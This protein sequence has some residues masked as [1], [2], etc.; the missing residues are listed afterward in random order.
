MDSLP[1]SGPG[2][3]SAQLIAATGPEE[4]W[5]ATSAGWLFHYS[6][7]TILPESTDSS[8]GRALGYRAP[9]RVGRAVRPRYT[10]AR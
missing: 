10:P 9:E 2:R 1:V 5:L 7:G 4:A 8:A 6:N 3:G